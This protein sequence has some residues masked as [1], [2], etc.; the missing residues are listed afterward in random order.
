MNNKVWKLDV[1]IQ[2]WASK[3]ISPISCQRAECGHHIIGRANQYL[4]WDKEN[5]LPCT[6]KEHDLIH[7]GILKVENYISP[8]RMGNLID[9]RAKYLTWK[10]TDEFYEEKLKE[11]KNDR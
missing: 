4:R 5:I 3:Q 9:K 6:L 1:L 7:R 8:K 2:Q 11:L 10:P